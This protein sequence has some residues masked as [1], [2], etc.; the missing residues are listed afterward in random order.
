[1]RYKPQVLRLLLVCCC[2]GVPLATPAAAAPALAPS[3]TPA[4]P[5]WSGSL[6]LEGV[7]LPDKELITVFIPIFL[8]GG[9]AY[10]YSRQWTVEGAVETCWLGWLRKE[11]YLSIIPIQVRYTWGG[12]EGR[13][14]C[15]A[16]GQV[17][18]DKT[19]VGLLI[20]L[21]KRNYFGMGVGVSCN[22][23]RKV[24]LTLGA[25]GMMNTQK[26]KAAHIYLQLGYRFLGKP[27]LWS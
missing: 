25:S 24:R 20:G 26:K 13:W 14:S 2:A 7:K 23:W 6:F 3:K 19:S 11:L 9:V 4:P 5:R 8:G 21:Q 12:S 22:W 10:Q 1:M 17:V 16:R 18:I 15:F 27:G